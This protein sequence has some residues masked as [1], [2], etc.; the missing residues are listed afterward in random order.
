MSATDPKMAQFLDRLTHQEQQ[1]ICHQVRTHSGEQR[2][3]HLAPHLLPFVPLSVVR[4][5]LSMAK[6]VRPIAAIQA[7][8]FTNFLTKGENWL[9]LNDKKV[10][11]MFGLHPERGK[12]L[13]WLPK[14]QSVALVRHH[15]GT[16]FGRW[17]VKGPHEHLP[18]I[19]NW[20]YDVCG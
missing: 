1:I 16:G 8:V 13:S 17:D 6:A 7:K 5:S 2:Y 3:A 11:R 19:M 15:V 18:V 20:L 12:S 9:I 4:K 14:K 10:H